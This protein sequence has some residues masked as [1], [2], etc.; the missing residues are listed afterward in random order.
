MITETKKVLK[1]YDLLLF[2]KERSSFNRL[3]K[4]S[5]IVIRR[6][7]QFKLGFYERSNLSLKHVIIILR[8][9]STTFERL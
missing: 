6:I 9:L 2:F 3:N 4:R 8:E 1:F 7:R 5:D